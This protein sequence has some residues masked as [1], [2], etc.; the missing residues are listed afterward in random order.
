MAKPK[1]ALIPASQGSKLYSVLP[2]GGVGDF[3]FTRNSSA[4]RIN[5]DGLIETVGSG[6]SRLNYPMIDGVVSGCP[7][8]ILEPLRRN[9]ALYSSSFDNSYWNKNR[10]TIISDNIIS[11]DGTQN[12]DK[13]LET[14]DNNSHNITKLISDNTGKNLSVSV[15]MKKAERNY[16][17]IYVGSGPGKGVLFDLE[18]GVIVKNIGLAPNWKKIEDYGNGWYRCSMG[19]TSTDGSSEVTFGIAKDSTGN[20]SYVG[21][22]SKGIYIWGAQVE[23]SGIGINADY[24]SSYI[25]TTTS[26]TTRSAETANGS[27]DAATFND[28]EGILYVNIASNSNTSSNYDGISISDGSSSDKVQLYFTPTSNQLYYIVVSGSNNQAVGFVTLNDATQFNKVAIKY[29]ANDFAFWVN[30]FEL[31]TDTSGIAPI[32]LD[33]LNFDSGTGGNDFYGNTKQIQYYDTALSDTDLETLTSWVSFQ[34]MAE[35]Q[36]YTIE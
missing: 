4:T 24:V 20:S 16:G 11:P 23:D 13:F 15:F 1:L 2:S 7:S 36:L 19:Y 35:G 6:V 28:S 12:A 22:A 27:G 25:P 18:D 33:T 10:S 34:E 21:D 29:K 26:I 5:K 17:V 30:G 3:D 31:L 9:I 8:H 14:T 32:G